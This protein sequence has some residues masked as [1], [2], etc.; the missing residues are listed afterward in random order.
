MFTSIYL[1]ELGAGFRLLFFLQFSRFLCLAVLSCLRQT[2]KANNAPGLGACACLRLLCN[3]LEV[4]LGVLGPCTQ[5]KEI[6]PHQGSLVSCY[7]LGTSSWLLCSRTTSVQLVP[8]LVVAFMRVGGQ[9]PVNWK[10]AVSGKSPPAIPLCS[11]CFC[12]GTVL[13]DL[14]RGL[15][16]I[17]VASV[18]V[19]CSLCSSLRP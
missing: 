15:E 16:S 18:Q 5:V 14:L 2:R 9:T 10:A 7:D 13:V 3:S 17:S 8:L 19:D 4:W 1:S 11:L 6:P 12:L